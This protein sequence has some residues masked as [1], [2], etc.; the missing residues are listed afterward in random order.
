MEKT[1]ALK[2]LDFIMTNVL[3]AITVM[4]ESTGQ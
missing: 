4:G 2:I 3:Q 1:N